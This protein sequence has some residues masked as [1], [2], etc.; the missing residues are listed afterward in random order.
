MLGMG[1]LKS[2]FWF[3]K[4]ASLEMNIDGHLFPMGRPKFKGEVELLKM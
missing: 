3:N 2:L 1:S 4:L